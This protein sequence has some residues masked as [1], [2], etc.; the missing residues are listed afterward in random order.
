MINH[1]YGLVF[2]RGLQGSNPLLPS[3]GFH[4]PHITLK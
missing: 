2:E 4:P 3:K 1:D